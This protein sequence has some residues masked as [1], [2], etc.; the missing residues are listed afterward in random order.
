MKR[1]WIIIIIIVLAFMGYKAYLLLNYTVEEREVNVDKIFDKTITISKLNKNNKTLDFQGLHLKNDYIGFTKKIDEETNGVYYIKYNK[2]NEPEKA[3]MMHKAKQY[4]TILTDGA[5]QMCS[6]LDTNCPEDVFFKEEER[7]DFIK[8]NNINN[9]IDLINY[10]KENYYLK[11]NIFTSIK[12]I[13]R[14]YMINS[15][16]ETLPNFESISKIEGQINGYI[17]HLD[18]TNYIMEMHLFNQD[19]QYIISLIGKDFQTDE[20]I[21]YFLTNISFDE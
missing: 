14:N 11:N 15:F 8:E 9:D 13:K 16:V 2:S 21:N 1:Y 4:Y 6:E 12:N 10:I 3:I 7:L 5:L 19:N 17:L 20:F 18:T